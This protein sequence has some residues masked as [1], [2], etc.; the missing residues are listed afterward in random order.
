[1]TDMEAAERVKRKAKFGRRLIS[2]H[3]IDY[4]RDN[5]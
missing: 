5:A 1:M 2:R 4:K 3:L